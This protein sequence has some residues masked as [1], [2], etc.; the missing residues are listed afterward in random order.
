MAIFI[1]RVSVADNGT[2]GNASSVLY[3]NLI[4]PSTSSDGRYVVLESDASNLVANDTN[5]SRNV[6]VYDRVNQS[7]ELIPVPSEPGFGNIPGF[8]GTISAD[9]R[10]VAFQNSF[11]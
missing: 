4:Y 8:N 11:K 6:F 10:Y 7:I 1:Q 2:Q 3:G 9:G 5:F